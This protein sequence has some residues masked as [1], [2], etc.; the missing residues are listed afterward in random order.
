MRLWRQRSRPAGVGSLMQCLCT[1]IARGYLRRRHRRAR[2]APHTELQSITLTTMLRRSYLKASLITLATLRGSKKI[3]TSLNKFCFKT[4]AL[5]DFVWDL[6]LG[7]FKLWWM[8]SHDCIECIKIAMALHCKRNIILSVSR[9]S[10]VRTL[11]QLEYKRLFNKT[12]FHNTMIGEVGTYIFINWKPSVRWRVAITPA[13][14]NYLVT[15]PRSIKPYHVMWV[16][17]YCKQ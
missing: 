3:T 9:Y 16:I 15:V 6:K 4:F 10:I 8:T 1:R 14:H 7:Q 11:K 13:S 2:A 12:L 5:C 17:N